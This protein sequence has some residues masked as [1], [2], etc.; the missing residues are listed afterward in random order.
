MA[1]QAPKTETEKLIA[2]IWMGLLECER[3]S[4]HHRFFQLGGDSIL[5][6]QLTSQLREH[7]FDLRVEDIFNHQTLGDLANYLDQGE[8]AKASLPRTTRPFE[9]VG[10]EDRAALD[11]LIVDA[12]PLG[13]LQAGMLYHSGLDPDKAIYHD[14]FSFH[15]RCPFNAEVME[16][17]ITALMSR[18]PILRTSF[19]MVGFTQ[20]LQLVWSQVTP[21][22]AVHDI[23]SLD[24][25]AQT[26]AIRDKIRRLQNTALDW[27]KPPLISFHL[28]RE[29]ANTFNSSSTCTTPFWM[30]GVFPCF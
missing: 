10:E 4:T 21:S 2:K 30:V 24:E 5:S 29:I 18:H 27:R 9:L 8:S 26:E 7:G 23:S 3:V 14:V 22:V 11:D 28:L 25:A 1:Y 17:A 16:Q 15:L 20:P 19:E 6:I 13:H 12:Y